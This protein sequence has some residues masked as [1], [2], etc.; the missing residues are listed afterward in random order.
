MAD[1]VLI[2][3]HFQNFGGLEKYSK[4]II[5]HF[6]EKNLKIL[7]LTSDAK[8]EYLENNALEVKVIKPKGF[9]KFQ[10]ILDFDK[11]CKK[12]LK[13]VD[14]KTIFSLDRSSFHTHIRLGNGLHI[15]YLERRKLYN[16][17]IKKILM[18]I[19]PLHISLLRMEKRSFENPLLKKVFVN[20]R[21]IKDEILKF[22]PCYCKNIEV[23]HNGVDLETSK[24]FFENWK[25][26]KDD[27]IKKLH[28]DPSDFHFL[29]NGNDYKRKGLKYL[30]HAL[31]LIKEEKF[32]LSVI[33]KE[34]R[35]KTYIKLAK[36]LN[37]QEKVSFFNKRDDIYN[38]YRLADALVI[39]SFYDPFANVTIEA[40]SM[41]VY[42]I[43]S[44]YNGAK[45]IVN[46]INGKIIDDIQDEKEFSKV[47]QNTIINN[48][49]TEIKAKKIKE[50]VNDLSLQK[51]IE[52]L[53]K[54]L[55]G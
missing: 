36:K 44:K 26:K 52:L 43:T 20:S 41:G 53:I 55:N 32:H 49:K 28:L 30:L 14:C 24:I 22:Y 21:M 2:K 34:S 31:S 38:F 48:K 54:N 9:F 35:I 29:F 3:Y 10:K 51:Q 50:S 16:S 8:N 13:N 12:F 45:E 19:N 4:A 37:L 27:F 46:A 1:I 7:I 18:N 42:V 47:L 5:T 33:G 25:I 11:K 15:A 6:L 17:K 39:P 40:L 23:I